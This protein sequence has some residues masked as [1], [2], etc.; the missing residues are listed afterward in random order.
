MIFFLLTSA[1]I[2]VFWPKIGQFL[3]FLAEIFVINKNHLN[4]LY[5][6]FSGQLDRFWGKNGLFSPFL[7]QFSLYKSIGDLGAGRR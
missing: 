7:G 3:P 4:T 2:A 1:K 6:Q 5:D